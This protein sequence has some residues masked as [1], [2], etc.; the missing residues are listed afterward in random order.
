[1]IEVVRYNGMYVIR[2][3]SPNRRHSYMGRDGD[4][5]WTGPDY[6]SVKKYKTR[7]FATLMAKTLHKR[8]LRRD[9]LLAHYRLTDGT[10]V[11][12]PKE[13]DEV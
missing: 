9:A 10:V 8:K 1:M 3:T 7:F 6:S 13:A 5:E 12:R 2:L 11:W 4:F